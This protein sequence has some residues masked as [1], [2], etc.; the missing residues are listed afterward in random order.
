VKAEFT[1]N[2]TDRSSYMEILINALD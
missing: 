1:E 2:A